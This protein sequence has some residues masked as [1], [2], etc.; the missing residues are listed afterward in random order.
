MCSVSLWSNWKAIATFLF[1]FGALCNDPFLFVQKLFVLELFTPMRILLQRKFLLLE[2]KETSWTLLDRFFFHGRSYIVPSLLKHLSFFATFALFK[3]TKAV[4]FQTLSKFE[5]G[6]RVRIRMSVNIRPLTS[7]LTTP[8]VR[9][10][11]SS[12]IAAPEL[13]QPLG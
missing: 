2:K 1:E 8:R 10:W 4:G 5:V 7:F 12:S 11:I 6:F 13:G 3:R 9:Y